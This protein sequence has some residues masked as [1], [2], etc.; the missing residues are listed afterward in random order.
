MKKITVKN[1]IYQVNLGLVDIPKNIEK[2]GVKKMLRELETIENGIL[3]RGCGD[4]IFKASELLVDESLTIVVGNT[5]RGGDFIEE[6]KQYVLF[7]FKENEV[8]L[9]ELYKAYPTFE[10]VDTRVEIELFLKDEDYREDFS[11]IMNLIMEEATENLLFIRE[12][13]I[14]FGK[15]NNFKFTPMV[16]I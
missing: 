9:E 2:K 15:K 6:I 10:S 13:V 11:P 1:D 5:S 8:Y 7:R 14:K 16:V 12:V 4:T 3:E